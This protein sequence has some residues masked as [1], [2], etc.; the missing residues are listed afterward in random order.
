MTQPLEAYEAQI[1]AALHY[2]G[3]THTFSDVRDAVQAGS[4]Q[5]WPGPQSVIITEIIDYPR[6]RILNFFLAGGNLAEL[7]AMYP[8]V[9]EWGRA[10]G[11]SGAI[12]L[13][14]KGWK[15]TFLT[16]SQGW[17]ETHVQLEKV[18]SSGEKQDYYL[19]L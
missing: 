9:D 10:Q 3:G 1:C 18:F 6:K 7:E 15:R 16:R 12:T 2:S 4:L 8:L 17:T 13:C 19:D 5:F 11:C 14:R